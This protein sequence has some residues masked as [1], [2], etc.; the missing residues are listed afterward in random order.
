LL[1]SLGLKVTILHEQANG[2]RTVIEKFEAHAEDAAFAVVLLTPDDEGYLASKPEENKPRARQ[3]VIL[4]LGFFLGAL[5]RTNVCAL[6]KGNVE[7]PSDINGVLYVP[8]DEGEAWK[9]RLAKEL[10]AAGIDVDMN[11]IV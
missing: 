1:E 5:G 6:H 4:E 11:K 2:G 10:R 3:N 8:L 9:F 7:L